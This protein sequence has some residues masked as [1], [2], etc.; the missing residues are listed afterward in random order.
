MSSPAD[1]YKSGVIE[2]S[3]LLGKNAAPVFD[4]GLCWVGGMD[5]HGS[6]VGSADAPSLCKG[7]VCIDLFFYT[8]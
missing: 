3:L 6:D 8:S 1:F 2:A 5:R 4:T 7:F